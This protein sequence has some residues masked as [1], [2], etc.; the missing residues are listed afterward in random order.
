M[1][2]GGYRVGDEQVGSGRGQGTGVRDTV[3]ALRVRVVEGQV[4]GE[5]GH[6]G[7]SVV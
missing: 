3:G 2:W 6:C 4:R 5:E 7:V 1:A